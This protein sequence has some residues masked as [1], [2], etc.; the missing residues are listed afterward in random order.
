MIPD[1]GLMM[2]CYIIFR[3][4]AVMCRADA[5]FA[6]NGQRI[7]VVVLGLGCI[8][9]TGVLEVD[10]ILGSSATGG[11]VPRGVF[12]MPRRRRNEVFQLTPPGRC[13]GRRLRLA[14]M[15]EAGSALLHSY[16]TPLCRLWRYGSSPGDGP[17]V[18]NALS[19]LLPRPS[20]Q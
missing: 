16:R 18:A 8:L 10:L 4:A 19:V 17:R 9:A 6:S 11:N 20:H 2:S 14:A 3:C 5:A 12:E 13:A 7:L 1:I 15:A